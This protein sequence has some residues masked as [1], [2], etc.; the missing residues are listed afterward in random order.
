MFKHALIGFVAVAL[1]SACSKSDTVHVEIS[2]HGRAEI[3]DVTVYSGL[4]KYSMSMI[5]AG[6]RKTFRLF[7]DGDRP[8]IFLKFSLNGEAMSWRGPEIPTGT[9]YRI[10]ISID[11]LGVISE[12]DCLTP[13]RL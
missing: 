12:R 9:G 5:G 13:C 1:L 4:D 6:D 3:R 10:D 8:I 7:P 11:A 2:N